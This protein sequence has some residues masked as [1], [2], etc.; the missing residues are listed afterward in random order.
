MIFSKAKRLV[1]ATMVA[2][3]MLSSSSY[4][5]TGGFSYTFPIGGGTS[6]TR[7]EGYNSAG[8]Q[9][10][11][12]I[13]YQPND[14][15]MP[16]GVRS[17]DQFYGS[18]KTIS[19]ATAMVEAQGHTVLGGVNADFFNFSDGVPTGLVVDNGRLIAANTWQFAV[20]FMSNGSAVIGQ[21][22]SN[23]VVSGESGKIAV[24]GYN[25]TR[26]DL[27]LYLFDRYYS[28][29]THF[30]SAGTSI[31]LEYDDPSNLRIGEPASFT[32]VDKVHSSSSFPIGENQ[33]VLTRRDDCTAMPWIDYQ[34]GEKVT[35]DFQTEA[36]AWGQVQYAVGGKLL[37]SNGS[38]T[39][40]G[41][42]SASSRTARS[43]VGLKN[44]GSVV[45]YEV[46]GLQSNYSKGLNALELGQEL[47]E[48]GCTTAIALD[49]GGSS[50]MTLK[51][52]KA[53]K[54]QLITRP[55]EGSE[56][57][58][59][60]FIFMI[61]KA[62]GDGVPRTLYL[63]PAA[64]YVLPGGTV[65]FTTTAVD[66]GFRT[67][68]VPGGLTYSASAGS[69]AEG[70]YTAPNDPGKVS[71]T[72]SGGEASGEMQLFVTNEP[73]AM[74]V[75]K[76][77]A[78]VSSLSLAA[79]ETAEIDLAV[80]R[81]GQYIA[82]ND[83][84]AVWSV[85][86][87]VG[88]VSNTGTFTALKQGAGQINVSCYGLSKSISVSV[89][90]GTAQELTTV[91]DFESTQPVTGSSG[92]TLSRTASPDDVARGYGALR[93]AYTLT[94]EYEQFSVGNTAT[95]GKKALTLWAKSDTNG[96][97]LSAVFTNGS[98]TETV[99]PLSGTVG[100]AYSLLK[101]DVP[102]D[103]SSLTGLRL[104]SSSASGTLYLDHILLSEH[105]VTNTD[106]PAI[107]V[108]DSSLK[109]DAGAAASVT[110]RITQE[111]GA[112]PL[113]TEQVHAYIDGKESPAKYFPSTQSIVVKT[114]GLKAGTHVI[115]LQAQDDAGNLSRKAFTVT[116][117]SRTSHAFSDISSSWAA[118]YIDLLADRGIMSG[119][120]G[121]DGTM[122]FLPNDNLRRSEFAVIMTK[123]L[124]LDTSAADGLP[125]SDLASIPDWA[126]P[127]V[128]AVYQAGIMS[129]Q[130]NP[131]TNETFFNPDAEI[132][133]A[134]VM[135]VIAR[136]LPRGYAAKKAA[137]TDASSIP[138]W[139]VSQ[140]NYTA[141]AGII[142]GY[143]DGSV[144]P[145]GKITRAEISSVICNFR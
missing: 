83:A 74:S 16:I 59:S 98:G 33:M 93:A 65:E 135:S 109:V 117:G 136:C 48:L 95:A 142:S 6:Y 139:A 132:T 12:V 7:Q 137:F 34:I 143:T 55:S 4:A 25:K 107:S 85:T 57:K 123:V 133:R 5:L 77:G 88:T 20:G 118:G 29:E 21:P 23:I 42:D 61:N 45:L 68:A 52:P 84:Q 66:S 35:I 19:Q 10:A 129:G 75:L 72:A 47:K 46:D 79:G 76:G 102:S 2:A 82:S 81:N 103:A 130:L 144:K 94:G 112:F 31:I 119:A 89:G 24:F 113:R 122:R 39:S 32:V 114:D 80:Y 104:T 54:A 106:A 17:G 73:T 134:E 100:P 26:T 38:V 101:A 97:A 138:S 40:T 115:T 111:N 13:T 128:A 145:L 11:S 92:L 110:A 91:A 27:G 43:A 63:E 50:A 49:G 30:S 131:N 9:K 56:R 64:R 37:M 41:I 124:G 70:K 8:L 18:R 15:V 96:A 44:D 126:K 121:P 108:T 53:D 67:A 105:A 51:T 86:G 116:A 99:I 78:A 141:S 3:V 14:G 22:V 125:F 28:N 140:V 120:A 87:G 1:A 69:V 36:S 62:Q 90:M 127:S 71:V 60:T 58:C